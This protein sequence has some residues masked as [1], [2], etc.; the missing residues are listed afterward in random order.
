[1]LRFDHCYMNLPV[2]AVEFLDAFI[3]LFRDANQEVWGN[4]I[5][6]PMVHVYGFTFHHEEAKAKEY[7]TER[8]GK[9]M[10][11]P[12]FKEADI[13]HCHNIRTVSPQSV[14][15]GVSFRLPE[16]VAFAEHKPK[17]NI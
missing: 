5:K 2:D 11:Y 1:M 10:N 9:A 17:P 8:I 12:E 7:F 16:A 13:A 4:P 14:M 6:L 15:Y 3:G